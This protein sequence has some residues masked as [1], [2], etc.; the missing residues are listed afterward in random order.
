MRIILDLDGDAAYFYL[1][2]G[3]QNVNTIWITEDMSID[4]GPNEE[5]VGLEVL[6]AARHLGCRGMQNM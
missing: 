2:E 6:S 4:L 1:K 3:I 5:I